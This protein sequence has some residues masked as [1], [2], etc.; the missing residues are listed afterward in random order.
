MADAAPVYVPSNYRK[1]NYIFADV[2]ETVLLRKCLLIVTDIFYNC[3][4]SKFDGIGSVIYY[5]AEHKKGNILT[6]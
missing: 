3:F 1:E 2:T 5:V 6:V 4:S